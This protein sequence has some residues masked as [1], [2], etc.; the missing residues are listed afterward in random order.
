MAKS[1]IENDS[2]LLVEV[3]GTPTAVA[4]SARFYTKSDNLPYFQDGAG[5]ERSL[6]V[7]SMDQGQVYDHAQTVLTIDTASTWHAEGGNGNWSSEKLAG[8][9]FVDG[10]TATAVTVYASA[11]GGAATTVTAAGHGLSNDD[12][13]TISGSTNYNNTG[14]IAHSVTN[15]SGNDFEINVAFAGDDAAGNVSRGPYLLAGADAA[16]EYG[17][18]MHQSAGQPGGASQEVETSV[19]LN[20]DQISNLQ[21]HREYAAGGDVGAAAVSAIQTIAASD[22]L[23]LAAR[24]LTGTNDKTNEH[25]LMY[26]RRA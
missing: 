21:Y 8:W 10:T 14:T 12:Q 26:L 5:V 22:R 19:F 9:T 6:L 20:A 13:C 16:G 25:F 4:G 2:L 1:G 3:S 18:H 11:D 17:I 15:V 23:W 7:T 24:N